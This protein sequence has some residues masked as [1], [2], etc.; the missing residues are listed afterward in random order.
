MLNV[1]IVEDEYLVRVG[2]K[3]SID[4]RGNGFN[5][6]DDAV[7]GI[8]AYNKIKELKPDIVLLDINIPR[9][10][11]LE[12]MKRLNDER[13]NIY[14]IIISCY[15]DFNSVRTALKYGAKDYIQKLTLDPSQLLSV[16]IEAKNKIDVSRPPENSS[17]F[18]SSNSSSFLEMIVN[19][20]E[21]NVDQ[22][23]QEF[24]CGF[25]II[26][27]ILLSKENALNH[28]P[29]VMFDL[30]KQSI[31]N[32][33]ISS[34]I[35]MTPNGSL[36]V[37]VFNLE[38]RMRQASALK[39]QLES[40]MNCICTVGISGYWYSPFEIDS[41]FKAASCIE[42]DIF[43]G[44]NGKIKIYDFPV[45]LVQDTGYNISELLSEIRA[46]LEILD[47]DTVNS[48]ISEF[49][50]QFDNKNKISREFV[51]KNL[52]K[53]ISLFSSQN[54]EASNLCVD[55]Q[56]KITSTK[57]LS[58]LKESFQIFLNEYS[59]IVIQDSKSVYPLIVT[60]AI[61]YVQKNGYSNLQLS[62]VA[63]KINVSEPYLCYI[64]KKT[65]GKNFVTYVSEYKIE[66][67]KQMLKGNALVYEVSERLGYENSNYFAKVFKRF[68]GISP[69]QYSEKLKK[70]N[71]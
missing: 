42:N 43:F 21:I 11:G 8:D 54:N 51:Y 18:N 58:Q 38:D 20:S 61:E 1:L 53:I 9:L 4:W 44:M 27:D 45:L 63:K 19:N 67:A 2:L 24:N 14:I 7:D 62:D 59:N 41:C 47:F 31:K 68:T 16:L 56:K 65:T 35:C 66:L 52:L 12:L 29:S 64:F 39:A 22:L 6:V 36:C 70:Y 3:T 71:I 30:C 15:D 50:Q 10:S 28:T 49:F 46:K 34:A 69:K 37:S 13:I 48:K 17:A 55:Y 23:P 25:F 57:R 5:L 32:L 60:Q 26:V 40:V 33:G